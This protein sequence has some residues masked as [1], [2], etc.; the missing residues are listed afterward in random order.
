[1][2]LHPSIM[3]R[4]RNFVSRLDNTTATNR[5][6]VPNG[7]TGLMSYDATGNLTTDTYTG[8]GAREYDAENKM[9]R[10]W[11]GNNQWQQYTYNADG[12][13]VRRKIDGQETWQ[14]Y[15]MDGELV[16][17]YGANNSAGSP[18][19]EYGYRNGQ[20]LINAEAPKN[21]ALAAN[22]AAVTVSSTLVNPPYSYP[23]AAVNNGDRKGVNA[24]FGGNWAANGTTLPQWVQIDFNGLKTIRE[25]S[26]LSLQ[27]NYS[28]PIE[29]TETTS[30]S[31]WG[32]TAF[33]VQYW[34]GS[35][36]V[37]VPGGSVTGNNKV[38]KKITFAPIDTSKIKVMVNTTVDSWTRVVEVEAW[39]RNINWLVTDQLGTPRM[40]IDELGTL[41]TVK[42]HDYLPFGEE[43]LAPTGGRSTPFG[44]SGSDAVRQQ[45]TQKE[46]D[47]ETGL[48]YFEAR[49]YASTQGRFTSVD[50]LLASAKRRNP[51][52]WNRY[53]YGMNNPLRF[54]DPDGEA[55]IDEDPDLYAR[56]TTTTTEVIVQDA[57]RRGNII[58]QAKVT[59]TETKTEFLNAAGQVDSSVD[60]TTVTTATAENTGNG[61]REYSLDQRKTMANVAQNVVAVSREKLFDPTIAL[62]VAN[63]ETRLGTAPPGESA[64]HKDPK[65][66]PMQLS[67]TSGTT[68]TTDLRS[69]IA[70]SID[71][72]NR[73]SASTN[74]LNQRLQ[75]YNGESTKVAYASKAERQ[76]NQIRQSVKTNTTL[77]RLSIF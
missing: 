75:D 38:W 26:V 50:P 65:I 14:I 10:A 22:G 76:I 28:N 45:F 44:Y 53:T 30:F 12:Q 42:R 61:A 25:I 77:I 3:R 20:L 37:T 15:G 8:A 34:N 39:T 17:E 67:A 63:T 16:A 13:R 21:V 40:S 51:Q 6:V 55:A 70:G 4:A 52:T 2:N 72:F 7:Q 66:N 57:D 32:L 41:A 56:R 18:Q 1:M 24:G 49:Y 48:D 58:Q 73:S 74:T 19:K 35:A 68:A 36:W 31:Q 62:G 33:N 5:L 59:V 46:R 43:L 71:V 47:V 11:G 69:N 23:A 29:P 60:P 9:T 54:T 27:D 64:A